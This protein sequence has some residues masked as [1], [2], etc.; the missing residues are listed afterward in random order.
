MIVGDQKPVAV[1]IVVQDGAPGSPTPAFI[2]ATEIYERLARGQRPSGVPVNVWKGVPGPTGTLAVPRMPALDVAIRNLIVV[3]IDQTFFEARK[4]WQ[5]YLDALNSNLRE[6]QD[7]LLPVSICSDA[8]RAAAALADINCVPVKDP[9]NVARDELVFQAIF[10]TLLRLLPDGP[11]L[12]TELSSPQLEVSMLHAPPRVFLCHA[13]SD[14]DQLA[15]EIRRYIYEET[16]LSCFFDS[17]DIPHGMSVRASI[18]RSI[19]ESCLLVVWT[20]KFLESRW[21][22]A[23]VAEARQYQRPILVLDALRIQ[24]PRVVP[25]FVNMPVVRWR[26]NPGEV[27]SALLLELVRTR[28]TWALFKSTQTRG[29]PATAFRAYP[30]DKVEAGDLLTCRAFGAKLSK[31]EDELVVYPDPP[32]HAEELDALHSAFPKLRLR[33]LSE[34]MALWAAD[35]LSKE[36]PMPWNGSQAILSSLSIGLSVSEAET[37]PNLGLIAQHQEDFLVSMARQLILLG[38]RLLWGGDLRQHGIGERLEALVRAYHHAGHAPQDHIACYL[39][40]PIYRDIAPNELQERRAIADVLCLPQPLPDAT[41]EPALDAL[42]YSV[43][44]RKMAKDSHARI[45]LGGKLRGYAGRYPGVVEEALET[46]KQGIPLYVV[47]GFGGAAR[48]VFDAIVQPE[49]QNALRTAWDERRRDDSIR[50][51]HQRYDSLANSMEEGLSDLRVDHDVMLKDF[52][53]LGIG[54]LSARNR[55]TPEENERLASCQDIHEITALLVKG[56]S[57]L[58][59]HRSISTGHGMLAFEVETAVTSGAAG[60]G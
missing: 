40:W 56:L 25:S 32:L 9:L 59:E 7:V 31:L 41:E 33:S 42:C 43:L 3:L 37:W 2:L 53:E 30:P 13:K 1:H 20:D 44:R 49:N 57:K 6:K 47:G 22:Q 14:G 52:A 18:Q 24:S 34:W 10:T 26:D 28:H 23:E 35:G 38:G 45:I 60:C 15:R 46:V 55:L 58:A 12:G 51:I 4:E 16:Q 19:A 39:A 5:S 27:L 21:C 17:H 54:G 36:G 29:A 8:H 48:A 50:D 11:P